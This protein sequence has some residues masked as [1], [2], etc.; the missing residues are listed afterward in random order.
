MATGGKRGGAGERVLESRHVIGLFLLMLLFSGVFF[1]LGYVM[2]RSQYDGQVRAATNPHTSPEVVVSPKLEMISKHGKSNAPESSAPPA[3]AAAPPNSDWEFYHAGDKKK[4]EDHLKPAAPTP[5]GNHTP[6]IVKSPPPGR[7]ST[8][9]LK[10]LN[11]PLIASGAYTLQ[12]AA[13]TKETDA[14]ELA[15]RLQK[16]K[17][18][19][20]VLSPQ[21]DNYYRIQVGPYAD[22][23]SADAA[24]KGLEGA[25]FKAIVKH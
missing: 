23:K 3:G 11:P 6:G 2:G 10:S 16:K 5:T 9:S 14:M 4:M 1:S 24:K 12:V 17:F 7:D 18:P 8:P 15:T 20:F 13:L 22:L 21:R 25:G 19:A